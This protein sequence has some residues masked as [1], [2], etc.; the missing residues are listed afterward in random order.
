MKPGY[1]TTEFWVTLVGQLIAILATVGVLS[2]HDASTL[3]EA[4]TRIT[5]A[6]FTL[7]SSAA[8]VIHYVK[9]R[10]SLKAKGN[11]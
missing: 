7:G 9:A 2:A 10:T 5:T 3:T 1:L 11:S 6:A 8:V 4:A